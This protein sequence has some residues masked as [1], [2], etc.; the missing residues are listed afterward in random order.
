VH[1]YCTRVLAFNTACINAPGHYTHKNTILANLQTFT[2]H[3]N[4]GD[5]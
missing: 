2:G 5:Q 4:T 3:T 1:N